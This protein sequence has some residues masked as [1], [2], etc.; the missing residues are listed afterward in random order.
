M[1]KIV[2]MFLLVFLSTGILAE[3]DAK[4]GDEFRAT[5]AEYQEKADK[6]KKEGKSDISELYS[7][8]AEIKLDA[9][10]K[11]DKGEWDAIDWTEYHQIEKKMH[12]KK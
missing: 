7:R 10:A 1:K 5:A 4:G 9:A 11:A 6:Y 12:S 3:G 2:S 8:M